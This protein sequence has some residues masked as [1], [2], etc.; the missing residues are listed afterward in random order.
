MGKELRLALVW[1]K[2]VLVQNLVQC[3][4][5]RVIEARPAVHLYS[6]ARGAP[7]HRSRAFR[8]CL[9]IFFLAL[10]RRCFWHSCCCRD[11]D[12]LACDLA[13]PADLISSWRER[14][15]GQIMGLEIL[16]I[17]LGAFVI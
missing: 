2:K 15:D 16:S 12:R 10:V 11:G 13:P 3:I 17:A 1:W 9:N 14:Q 6:D 7:A 5:W 8:V 4:G